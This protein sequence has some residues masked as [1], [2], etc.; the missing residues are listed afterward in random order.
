MRVGIVQLTSTDDLE[1]NLEVAERYV[2]EAVGLGAEF[3]AL[4][5]MFAFMRREGLAF[6][7]A[8][9]VKGPLVERARGWARE[10]GVRLLAGTIGFS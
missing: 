7:H 6:P 10:L 8:Q 3:V 5:E 4:P 1:A 9:P 2:R